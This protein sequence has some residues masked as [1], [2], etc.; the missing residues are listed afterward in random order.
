VANKVLI[1][2]HGSLVIL[3]MV[4]CGPVWPVRSGAVNSQTA[5]TG[6]WTVGKIGPLRLCL[7]SAPNN[8]R[9]CVRIWVR[10]RIRVRVWVGRAIEVA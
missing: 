8:C 1:E 7:T 4:R 9:V 5:L 10:F 2:V 6:C 3:K